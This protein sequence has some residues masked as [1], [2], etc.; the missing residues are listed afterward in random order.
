MYSTTSIPCYKKGLK[1]PNVYRST[2]TTAWS[3]S[4]PIT[5]AKGTLTGLTWDT[6]KSIGR[7]IANTQIY[8]LKDNLQPVPI[9][10]PGRITHWTV[11]D[12]CRGYFNQPELTKEKFISNPFSDEPG[13][14]LYKT[15]DLLPRP[16]RRKY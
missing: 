13:S 12:V 14:R 1:F 3:P 7:P 8:I 9:G 4:Y 6:Q 2:E 5:K 15:G 10:V 16:P 11:L